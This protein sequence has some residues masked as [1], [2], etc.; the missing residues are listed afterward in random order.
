MAKYKTIVIAVLVVALAILIMGRL[1]REGTLE[2][3]RAPDVALKTLTGDTVR[4]SDFEGS[5]VMLNFWSAACPPCR[6]E[7]PAMQRVY[8]ELREEGFEIV[9]VNVNDSPTVAAQF[10]SENSYT[11][12]VLKD[13]GQASRTYEVQFIPKTLIIDRKG[14]IRY[15]KVG[16]I[17]EQALRQQVRKWL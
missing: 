12:I 9:A 13:D 7:M 5:V 6:E 8:D 16:A 14:V 1:R 11:F 17:S 3:N 4:L 2:G 10:I 15:I